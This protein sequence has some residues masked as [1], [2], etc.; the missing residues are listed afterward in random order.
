RDETLLWA[1]RP[2]PAKVAAPLIPNFFVGS[3]FVATSV[4][5]LYT[6][7]VRLGAASSPSGPTPLITIPFFVLFGGGVGFFGLMGFGIAIT[8]LLAL[9]VAHRTIYAIT[10]RRALICLIDRGEANFANSHPIE[11]TTKPIIT[12]ST[13]NRGTVVFQFGDL[14]YSVRGRNL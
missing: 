8:P 13:N 12:H 4:W 14:S 7:F 2:D 3:L 1:G 6:V 9:R 11:S 5:M 10:P